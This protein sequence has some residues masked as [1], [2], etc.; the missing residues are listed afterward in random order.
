MYEGQVPMH[1]RLILLCH[2]FLESTWDFE[3]NDLFNF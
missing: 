1:Q 3:L 2:D